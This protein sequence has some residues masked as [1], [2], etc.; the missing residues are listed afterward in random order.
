[1]RAPF[2]GHTLRAC[3]G[4]PHLLHSHICSLHGGLGRDMDQLD[5][6]DPFQ[7]QPVGE[8]GVDVVEVSDSVQNKL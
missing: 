7:P 6:R 4:D 1:M 2:S 8:V 3:A 5:P